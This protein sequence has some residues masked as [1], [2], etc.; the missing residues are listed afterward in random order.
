MLQVYFQSIKNL[1]F[2]VLQLYFDPVFKMLLY[3]FSN[4]E[5]YL[6]YTSKIYVTNSEVYLKESF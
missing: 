6:K 2:N 3:F 1:G 4:P 5:V